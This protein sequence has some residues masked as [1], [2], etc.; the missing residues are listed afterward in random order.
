MSEPTDLPHLESRLALRPKEAAEALGVSDRTL[1]DWMRNEDLP[2]VQIDRSILIP[3][4]NLIL[5]MEERVKS[6]VTTDALVDEILDE[7]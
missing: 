2:Y 7:F 3:T 1:R 4:A 6:H 5:W